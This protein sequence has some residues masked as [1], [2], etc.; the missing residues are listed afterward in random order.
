MK[1]AFAVKVTRVDSRMSGRGS[2]SMAATARRKEVLRFTVR[3]IS[4]WP[5]KG[6]NCWNMGLQGNK[7]PSLRGR[8]TSY[9][10]LV[11]SRAGRWN[12]QLEW[13]RFVGEH[14]AISLPWVAE[15]RIILP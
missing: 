3:R 15:A 1:E 7:G 4:L 8:A 10:P 14:E 13:R 12:L 11:N 9:S 6:K 5:Q 2:A